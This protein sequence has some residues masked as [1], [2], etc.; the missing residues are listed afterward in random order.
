M[1]ELRQA[2]KEALQA[3]RAVEAAREELQRAPAAQGVLGSQVDWARRRGKHGLVAEWH[4]QAAE[5]ARP[6][7]ALEREQERLEQAEQ[8]LEAVW[9][10]IEDRRQSI[11]RYHQRVKDGGRYDDLIM[12][13]WHPD[14]VA[15]LERSREDEA[16]TL[17]RL[18]DELERLC[19]QT[20][21]PDA[22]RWQKA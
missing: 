1:S 6:R 5:A 16:A 20:W 21:D 9:D 10:Q 14:R 17:R 18:N 13:E 8:R 11:D 4:E 15:E 3:W 19:G 22:R 7:R 12:R 2:K